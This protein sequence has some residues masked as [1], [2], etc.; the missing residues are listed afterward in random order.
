MA[1][2][3]YALNSLPLREKRGLLARVRK[4]RQ[5][6]QILGDE[7]SEHDSDLRIDDK[8]ADLSELPQLGSTDLNVGGLLHFLILDSQRKSDQQKMEQIV[9]SF[10]P[11]L[12]DDSPLRYEKLLNV[13][14]FQE[15][16]KLYLVLP[17]GTLTSQDL[18]PHSKLRPFVLD[19]V[20]DARESLRMSERDIL[21]KLVEKRHMVD[22]DHEFESKLQQDFES[23]LKRQ[24]EKRAE[25]EPEQQSSFENFKRRF[26]LVGVKDSRLSEMPKNDEAA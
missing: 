24:R 23:C 8:D 2:C 5:L 15:A 6:A 7:K 25:G 14:D 3:F 17:W 18:S 20:E 21:Q 11:I 19:F 26:K 4:R 13:L 9:R 22:D 16:I 10:C 1:D 12:P